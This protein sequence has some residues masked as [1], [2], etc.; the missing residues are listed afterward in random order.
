MHSPLLWYKSI[1]NN[2]LMYEKDTYW[3]LIDYEKIIWWIWDNCKSGRAMRL[4]LPQRRRQLYL[5]TTSYI[6]CSRIHEHKIW[7]KEGPNFSN[8]LFRGWKS[9][10]C[11]KYDGLKHLSH[12]RWGVQTFK[13][14]DRISTSALFASEKNPPKHTLKT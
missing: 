6:L 12:M 7:F 9:S 11:L 4:F 14:L 10:C 8:I 13:N 5:H 3:S 1:P 2:V